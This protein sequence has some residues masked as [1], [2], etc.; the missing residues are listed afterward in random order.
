M[1]RRYPG[2]DFIT[3]LRGVAATMVVIIHTGAFS[4]LGW[5]GKNITDAGKAGVYIFFVIAGFSV[6]HSFAKSKTIYSYATQRFLRL[7]PS[8]YIV[9]SLVFLMIVSNLIPTPFWGRE[10]GV[11]YD[12][13]NLVLHY[14]FLSFVDYRV[15]NSIIGVEWTLPIELF[16]YAALVPIIVFARSWKALLACLAVAWIV[17]D[18]TKPMLTF[19][20]GEN[21]AY[22]AKFSPLHYGQ[23]FIM[24]VIAYKFRNETPKVLEKYLS[25]F[26]ILAAVLFFMTVLFGI[27]GT[28][29]LCAIATCLLICGYRSPPHWVRFAL[30]SRT[31][32]FLGTIS[33]GMYLLHMPWIYVLGDSGLVQSKLALFAVV[34]GLTIMSS[35]VLYTLV[36]RPMNSFG[37]SLG[38]RIEL[39]AAQARAN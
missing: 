19:L 26:A 25:V 34:Y 8:Y 37:R 3:G 17:S 30:E 4:E 6:C 10:T 18:L 35:L 16:W 29:L 27:G 22:A 14:L 39:N 12:A 7:A 21:G 5:I 23:Y 15:A 2:T 13:W 31:M 24:G 28:T 33:Y 1:L 36:E 11:E 38:K 32:L 20:M 9:L